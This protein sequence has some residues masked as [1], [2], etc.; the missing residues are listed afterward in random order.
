MAAGARRPPARTGDGGQAYG[1]P[2][3]ERS[4]ARGPPPPG[5]ADEDGSVVALGAVDGS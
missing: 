4:G 2:T 3:G 5:A 1:A